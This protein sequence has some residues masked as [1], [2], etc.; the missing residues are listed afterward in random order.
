MLS[1]KDSV[2]NIDPA[3]P[4]TPYGAFR[5]NTSAGS[6][7]GTPVMSKYLNDLYGA[8]YNIL[9]AG[10]TIPSGEVE[11]MTT[12]SD[13]VKALRVLASQVQFEPQ[14]DYISEM[15]YQLLPHPSVLSQ[16]NYHK[17][18]NT[19]RIEGRA[20]MTW[21]NSATSAE[22][23]LVIPASYGV[24]KDI[25]GVATYNSSGGNYEPVVIIAVHKPTERRM[26]FH[27]KTTNNSVINGVRYLDYSLVA[28]F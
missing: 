15:R 16:G 3:T 6:A 8:L 10:D 9:A 13:I 24:V 12:P 19:L 5:D 28:Y 17:V 11:N 2:P 27:G 1:L 18:S 4:A 25:T 7:D 23:S 14:R 22:V 20:Q 21:G 26:T